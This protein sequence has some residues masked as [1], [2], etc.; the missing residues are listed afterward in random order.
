MPGRSCLSPTPAPQLIRN[1][2]SKARFPFPDRLMGEDPTTIEKHLSQI[3]QTQLVAQSPQHDEQHDIGGIFQI[4]KWSSCAFIEG[5][6]TGRAVE[7]LIAKRGLLRLFFG[8]RGLAV[9]A[10]HGALP[11]KTCV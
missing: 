8:G 6:L 9:W 11:L 3:S 1:E 7:R 5:T 10:V 4:V 2:E